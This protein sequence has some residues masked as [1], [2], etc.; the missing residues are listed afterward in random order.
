MAVKVIECVF[1]SLVRSWFDLRLRWFDFTLTHF[2]FQREKRKD[3]AELKNHQNLLRDH[4]L[5][6]KNPNE[7]IFTDWKKESDQH[8]QNIFRL[9][10]S[11]LG[12]GPEKLK[13][14]SIVS[15]M[16]PTPTSTPTST[17]TTTMTTMTTMARAAFTRL[18]QKLRTKG[19]HQPWM[20]SFLHLSKVGSFANLKMILV[21][22]VIWWHS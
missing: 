16:T 18:T 11:L 9:L 1:K 14:F 2:V 8:E 20:I 7:A 12:G 21:Y 10:W 5:N 13:D 17:P 6:Q 3:N 19:F 4:D 22:D 15:T